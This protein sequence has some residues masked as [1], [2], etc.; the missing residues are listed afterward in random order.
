MGQQMIIPQQQDFY[1]N[2]KLRNFGTFI[3]EYFRLKP[4][5]STHG[6][7]DYGKLEQASEQNLSKRPGPDFSLL[8]CEVDLT[9]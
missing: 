4:V 1:C 2:Q 7:A 9:Y 8:V 6:T 3:R 5:S